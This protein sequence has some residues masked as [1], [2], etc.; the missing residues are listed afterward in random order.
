MKFIMMEPLNPLWMRKYLVTDQGDPISISRRGMAS[1]IR[2]WKRWSRIG[3]VSGIK[4][5][6]ESGEWA[7]AKKTETNF[8]CYRRWRETFYD[9]ENVHG[10]ND[11][12]SGIHGKELPEQLS[13]HCEH[14]RSHTQTNVRHFYKIGVWTRWVLRIGNN[15]LGESFME[16][17]VIAWW[18]KRWSIFDA[19][20]VYV[21]FGFCV[22][23]WEDSRKHLNRTMHGSKRLGWIKS[24]SKYR[25]FHRIDGEPM[26]FEWNIFPG[27]NTLQLSE[28]V[29]RLLFRLEETPDNFTGR[30]IYVDVQRHFLW[31]KRQW[32]RMPDDSTIRR[33]GL[34][35]PLLEWRICSVRNV[36]KITTG[37]S[38]DELLKHENKMRIWT[39][40]GKTK[41]MYEWVTKHNANVNDDI[42]ACVALHNA[43]THNHIHWASCAFSGSVVVFHLHTHMH[44]G[45]SLSL[46][47]HLHGHPRVCGLFTLSSLS[48]SCS[49]FRPFSSSSTT[50]SL[51]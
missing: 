45:S 49:T 5:I 17:P 14:N 15:W 6:R 16:I 51:W 37:T 50:W 8:K 40:S 2:H 26:E 25:N 12:V 19:R 11:G 27:F 22:V 44:L 1:T 13:I 7:S 4:I 43:H 42:H 32:K 24:S 41:I 18:R 23:P 33:C 34:W 31:I 35:I 10:C 47:C 20:Q 21:L 36:C 9:L 38:Y 30:T 29:K 3:I 28:E 39:R 48:T 46:P